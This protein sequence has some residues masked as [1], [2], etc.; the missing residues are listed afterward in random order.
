VAVA[1][2]G[3][4]HYLVKAAAVTVSVAVNVDG[5][6]W[7]AAP[8]QYFL[9]DQV[10]V[11]NPT[12]SAEPLS[13]FDDIDTGLADDVAFVMDASTASADHDALACGVDA[14]FAPTL[15]PISYGQGVT[16]DSDSADHDDHVALTLAPGA[17]A[18]ITYSYGPVL[19][20]VVPSAVTATFTGGTT[21]VELTP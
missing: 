5:F 3:G 17:S 8:G 18:R 4:H 20:A 11:A 21:P 15:C 19:Q 7:S 6:L 16:V 13:G 9:Q 12:G 1:D 2:T 10:T 14:A